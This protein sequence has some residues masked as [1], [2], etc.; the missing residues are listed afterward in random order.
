MAAN[1]ERDA[2]AERE[3]SAERIARAARR[4]RAASAERAEMA[5]RAAMAAREARG[6]SI[7]IDIRQAHG[8]EPVRYLWGQIEVFKSEWKNKHGAQWTEPLPGKKKNKWVDVQTILSKLARFE[9]PAYLTFCRTNELLTDPNYW[10]RKDGDPYKPKPPI[11][12]V[13][14]KQY[15]YLEMHGRHRAIDF[16]ALPEYYR[17]RDRRIDKRPDTFY[18]RAPV[19]KNCT[20][21]GPEYGYIPYDYA[22]S[23]FMSGVGSRIKRTNDLLQLNGMTIMLRDYSDQQCDISFLK[24]SAT[25]NGQFNNQQFSIEGN[26]PKFKKAKP[27]MKSPAS[28]EETPTPVD[29]GH[30]IGGTVKRKRR[31]RKTRK[32]RK[33]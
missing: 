29:Q 11:R 8:S 24:R 28:I 6:E 21:H 18:Y 4:A 31:K 7:I 30:L 13:E 25:I 22:M 16:D 27:G 19:G 23:C 33:R 12:F 9:I 32:T 15:F 5:E 10:K 3:A 14:G 17:L 1:A 26:G 20:Q 2:S